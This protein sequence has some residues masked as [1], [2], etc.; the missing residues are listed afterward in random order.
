M[1]YGTNTLWAYAFGK[2][3]ETVFKELKA[4]LDPLGIHRYYTDDWRLM[5]GIWTLRN[6]K[7]VNGTRRTLSEK[8]LI[9]V[10]GL[11]D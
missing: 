5:G 7:L 8:I 11:S 2:R 3:K 4:L 6:M 1:D 10:L 9:F